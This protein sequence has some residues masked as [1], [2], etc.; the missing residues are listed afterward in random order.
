MSKISLKQYFSE[1]NEKEKNSFAKSCLTTV[2][3]IKQI[4]YG[5]RKCNPILAIAIDRESNGVV[6]CDDLCPDADFDYLR[7]GQKLSA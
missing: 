6:S 5:Y 7:N 1:L 3:H 2:G 4:M